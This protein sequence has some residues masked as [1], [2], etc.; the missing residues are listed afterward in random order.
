MPEQVIEDA[1]Y[2]FL[3]LAEQQAASDSPLKG[4]ELHA[5]IHE[6]IKTDAGVRVGDADAE[7][8]PARSGDGVQE[9]NAEVLLV[10]YARV[11]GSDKSKRAPSRRRAAEIAHAVCEAIEADS[12]LGGGVCDARVLRI[13][14]GYDSITGGDEYAVAVLRLLINEQ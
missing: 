14:R 8:G 10:C 1:L 2:D 5:T 11:V 7:P 12:S 9:Y 13:S 4:V 6:K 3:V